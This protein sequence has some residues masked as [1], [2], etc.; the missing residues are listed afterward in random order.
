ME[1][2]LCV[3]VFVGSWTSVGVSQPTALLTSTQQSFWTVWHINT[4]HTLLLMYCLVQMKFCLHLLT[5]LSFQT[6]MTLLCKRSRLQELVW[7]QRDGGW[8]QE[9]RSHPVG[10]SVVRVSEEVSSLVRIE[11][12]KHTSKP[13]LLHF[14]HGTSKSMCSRISVMLSYEVGGKQYLFVVGTCLSHRFQKTN[15]ST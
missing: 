2:R 5:F 7:D 3:G 9:M 6:C 8:W 11:S 14:L 12:T 15:V 4:A 1:G 13:F 10:C